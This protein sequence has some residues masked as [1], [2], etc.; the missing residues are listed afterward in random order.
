MKE[1]L[2]ERTG[3]CQENLMCF[4]LIAILTGKGDISKVVVFSQVPK[5]IYDI[6][7]EVVPLEAKFFRHFVQHEGKKCESRDEDRLV[8]KIFS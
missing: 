8:F 4:N 7:F 6:L 1:A 2:E 5:G 3:G